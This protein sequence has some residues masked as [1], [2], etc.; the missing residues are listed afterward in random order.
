MS[1]SFNEPMNEA[2]AKFLTD[3]LGDSIVARDD[4]IV[5]FDYVKAEVSATA[6]LAQLAESKLKPDAEVALFMAAREAARLADQ[7]S[8][9]A[10][11][12]EGDVVTMSDG[13]KYQITKQGWRRL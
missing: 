11:H 10:L 9:I 13:T 8:C 12:D 7:P 1:I 3:F 5:L 4:K 6:H 2:T